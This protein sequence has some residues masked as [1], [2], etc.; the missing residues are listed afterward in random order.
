M[1]TRTTL[2]TIARVSAVLLAVALGLGVMKTMALSNPLPMVQAAP[3][4]VHL[5]QTTA[6]K[7]E[8]PGEATLT[9][10]TTE[11]NENNSY[12]G[13]ADGDMGSEPPCIFR[14]D[15][16]H[17]IEFNINV[18]SLPP[19]FSTAW[20]SLIVWNVAEEHPDCP[21]VDEV[22]FNEHLVGYLRG[23]YETFS[24]S[25][26]Y[27]IDPAWVQEGN[28]LVEVYVN[29][30][31]CLVQGEERWCVGVKQGTLQLE[32]SEGAAWKREFFKSPECWP[33]GSTGYVYV[34][35]DTDLPSQEVMVE[36]NVLDPQGYVLVGY[37][38]TKVI[39]GTE[40]DA[41]MPGL[42]IPSY[43]QP[44]EYTIQ[45]IIY[46]T[47]S[48]TIQEINE[49]PVPINCVTVTTTPTHT[50]TRTP[51]RTPTSTLTATPTPTLTS[52]PTPTL[53]P[54]PICGDVA[55]SAEC[56]GVVDVKDFIL[57]LNYVGHPG[58]YPLCCEG[59]GDVSP[60]AQCD[61]VIDVGDFILLLNY[62]VHPGEYHLCCE[63]ASATTAAPR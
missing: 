54:T 38:E 16:R 2:I 3:D 59:C 32:G 24:T 29:T 57:L 27:G 14:T 46:D 28:N 21:E 10:V 7:E 50:P 11:D 61:G 22:H 39:H 41:F 25:G 42:P 49:H 45:V 30:T 8:C 13:Y 37:S 4:A 20:L 48:G 33:P 47:C 9:Y 12:T 60:S 52:T 31:G 34:E 58:E 55:P 53:T 63:A 35:V 43:A 5:S 17:P 40:N 19:Y 56:D 62:A 51:T 18:P 26:P 6:T 1:R 23:A 44:G 36:I 15:D